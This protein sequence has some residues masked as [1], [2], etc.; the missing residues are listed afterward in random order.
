[1]P[2]YPC[3]TW[4]IVKCFTQEKTTDFELTFEEEITLDQL[5]SHVKTRCGESYRCYMLK[6]GTIKRLRRNSDFQSLVRSNPDKVEIYVKIPRTQSISKT[7][8]TPPTSLTFDDPVPHYNTTEPG[9]WQSI[10]VLAN[11]NDSMASSSQNSSNFKKGHRR[12]RSAHASYHQHRQ[13]NTYIPEPLTPDYPCNNRLPFSSDDGGGR[14]VPDSAIDNRNDTPD[15]GF[16][17]P[18]NLFTTY[19]TDNSITPVST[20]VAFGE[21]ELPRHLYE[22]IPYD[23]STFPK[24]DDLPSSRNHQTRTHFVIEKKK[25]ANYLCLPENFQ[26]KDMIGSGGFAKVYHCIDQDTGRDLAVKQVEYDANCK[27]SDR[28]LRALKNEIDILK[29]LKHPHIVIYFGSSNENGMF[30]IFMEFV[31]GGSM[32]AFIQNN[33]PLSNKLAVKCLSHM[34]LGLSYLHQQKIIHRDLKAANVL[35]TADGTIKIADFGASKR[36]DAV[37]TIHGRNSGLNTVVGT[38]YWMSPEVI[39]AESKSSLLTVL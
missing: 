23:N 33:G 8:P 35:K 3:Q 34:L 14:F 11:S 4:C 37:R 26:I 31:S 7:A 10:G 15:S 19:S 21:N 5:H 1:M 20:P 36:L 13:V 39:K 6:E 16:Q 2:E 29:K 12:T 25:S 18:E 28:E 22:E 38:P 32:R 24:K 17:S 9:L 30:N 27:D